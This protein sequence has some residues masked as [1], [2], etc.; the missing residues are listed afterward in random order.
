MKSKLFILL[1]VLVLPAL[2]LA[3]SPQINL[4]AAQAELRLSGECSSNKL[5]LHWSGG[6]GIKLQQVTDLANSNWLDLPGTEG[7]SSC[8]LPTTNAAAFFRLLSPGAPVDADADGLDTFTET[9]GWIIAVDTSGY[10]DPQLVE[11]R[12]VTSDPGLA[13]TDGDGISDFW[14]WIYGTDPRSADTDRDGLTDHEEL[15]IHHTSPTSADTDGDARGPNHNL[16]PNPMLFDG[17]EVRVLHTSPTLDDT[18]GDGRTDYE[19]YDQPGRNALVAQVPKLAVQLVDAVDVRLDVQYAEELGT[20]HEY[21]GEL[22]VSDSAGFKYTTEASMNW[23]VSTSAKAEIGL[24][25]SA[26]VS[27]EASVGGEVSVGFEAEASHSVESSQSDYLTDSRTRTETVATGSMSAG[28]RLLNTGPI[29]YTITDLGLTVRYWM[30]GT[31]GTNGSFKTLATL[32]PVLG[33]NGITLAPGD[34]TPV[35]Q[36]Q[37]TSLNASR[38]KEFMARPNSLYLEPAFYELENAQ[39]LNFDYLE[40]VTRWR[41]A[42]VQIDYGDGTNE[43]YRVA[44]NVE[45]NQDGS[46]AGVTLGNVMSNILRIPFQAVPRRNLQPTSPTNERV[47]Y[48]VRSAVTT[49]MTNGFWAVVWSGDG[50]AQTNVDFEDIALHAGDHLLLVFVQD[51]DGD[52]LFAAEEQHYRTDDSA[53]AD[54]DGDGLTDA[55]EVR[56]GWDVKV[57]GRPP[58]HVF[59]D[60]AQADQ[61]GDGLTDYEEYLLGTDPTKA[62]TDSDGLPDGLDP[63]P[64]VPARVLR[65]KWDA[66]HGGNGITN[67]AT[68]D[69]ALTNL[70]DA[71]GVARAGA[72][73][74]N[75]DD[76]VAEIWVAAGVY[77]PTTTT[78]NRAARFELINNTAVYG[79]FSGGETK[80]SQRNSDPLLNGTILSGDL[81]TNDASTYADNPA[82]FGDNSYH[83]CF[84]DTNVGPGTILDGFMITGGNTLGASASDANNGGGGML[85]RGYPQL[86]N[87]AF[88]ANNSVFFGGG[89]GHRAAA[90]GELQVTDCLFLQNQALYGGGIGCDA[91]VPTCRVTLTGC[92]FSDNRSSYGGAINDGG[93]FGAGGNRTLSIEGSTFRLNTATNLG[94]AIYVNQNSAVRI[95]RCQFEENTGAVGGGIALPANGVSIALEVVQSVFF[96]N[97]S[98]STGGGAIAVQSTSASGSFYVLNSTFSGNKG[99]GWGMAIGVWDGVLGTG[100]VENSVLWGNTGSVHDFWS[101]DTTRR[102]VRTS[103]LPAGDNY[104]PSAGNVNADPKF[105][106]STNGNLR[107]QSGSPCIDAGNN[108]MDYYPRVPGLQL[109]PDTDLDGNWRIVDGNG[110]GTA[111]VDMGAY[112]NQGH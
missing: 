40:E 95:S 15:F 64:L 38:V 106:D 1:R 23:S 103:C 17:N 110:D 49:S 19:E 105:A 88:R 109:L 39:G 27:A 75:S 72:A 98:T 58:Y 3:A 4:H 100:V 89:L 14:E 53:T 43:E 28:V 86:R 61:D 81:L 56:T 83:V 12:H 35:L 18:D 91:S 34:K 104:W 68:W 78:T 33:A 71:L 52:G 90:G 69:A 94:G 47:L 66:A 82:S 11:L 7:A 93:N 48:S 63:H 76:D 92:Q 73:T 24:F 20:T 31:A 5:I 77:E 80:Q 41:T 32:V 84:A 67:G 102:T 8:E 59:P 42:R 111:R 65:V 21:G 10:G 85:C 25:P 2:L 57:A 6:P 54:S 16:P 99:A 62:D 70:Q 9:N 30:P 101:A 60:P 22:T 13:D 51:E 97:E 44:T 87:L 45:R 37:A 46:Y 96:K 36:V 107:L 50:P 79:G 108:Y 55:F 112:E 26:S 74:T 29:T